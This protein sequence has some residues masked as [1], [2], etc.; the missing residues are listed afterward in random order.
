MAR[1]RFCVSIRYQRHP[2]RVNL[3]TQSY[4]LSNHP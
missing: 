4:R 3:H 2:Y 1:G